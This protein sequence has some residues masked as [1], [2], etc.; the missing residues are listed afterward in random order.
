MNLAEGLTAAGLIPDTAPCE[1]A[2]SGFHH[3]YAARADQVPAVAAVFRDHGYFLEMLTCLDLRP[4]PGLMRLVYT[5]NLY[6]RADR[7]RVHVDLRATR[8][9]TGPAPKGATPAGEATLP[10]PTEGVSITH[11]FSA[12][13]WFEREVFDLMGIRFDGHPNLVRILMSED[14]EGHPLRKDYPIGGEPVRFSEAE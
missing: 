4:T 10:E 11:L 8:E 14:W 7:H 9:W 5:W 12:A 1:Y 13:D 2:R 6:E 3:G